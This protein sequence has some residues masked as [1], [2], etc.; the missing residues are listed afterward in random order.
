[1]GIDLSTGDVVDIVKQESS[2]S[3]WVET[4]SGQKLLNLA[5]STGSDGLYILAVDSVGGT[6]WVKKIS[7]HRVTLG[8]LGGTGVQFGE[9]ETTTWTFGTPEA[10]VS[11]LIRNAA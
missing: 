10:G 3:Y 5:D 9:D 1:M 7:A 11:V 8:T 2:Y 6:Y 4:G